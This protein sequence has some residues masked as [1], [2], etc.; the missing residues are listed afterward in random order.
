MHL[1]DPPV[2]VGLYI[3]YYDYYLN[4]YLYAILLE[5]NVNLHLL[6]CSISFIYSI[7]FQSI[8]S[9]SI[10]TRYRSNL[11]HFVIHKGISILR[12]FFVFVATIRHVCITRDPHFL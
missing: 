12:S 3:E 2:S 8:S 10:Y 7:V 1:F 5:L 11:I 9:F 4:S 6:V